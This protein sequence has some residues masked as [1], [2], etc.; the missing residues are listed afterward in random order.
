ME[1]EEDELEENEAVV[2]AQSLLPK[3][4]EIRSFLMDVKRPIILCISETWLNSSV[5]VCEIEVHDYTMYRRDRGERGGGVLVYVPECC[6]SWRRQDLEDDEV[7]AIWSELHLKGELI[8]VCNVYRP[9]DS[10][11]SALD[12]IS[13]MLEIAAGK[14]KELVLMG[15]LNCNMLT[16]N[17]L[18]EKLLLI[19]QENCLTQMISE[20]TRVT[21]NSQTLIDVLFTTTPTSFSALGILPL[22]GSDH[23]MIFGE[24]VERPTSI[25]KASIVRCYKKCNFDELL[26]EL[27]DTPWHIMDIYSSV[28]DMWDCW[29]KLFFS[30]LDRHAPL[31]SVRRR[32]HSLEWIDEEIRQMMR[33]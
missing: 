1:E 31:R 11:S 27:S 23:M 16:Q 14:S 13:N 17:A 26:S 7:E 21:A 4:D 25:Q 6:R 8:L 33:A 22:T 15:D 20:P 5:C 18:S 2:N 12:R 19:T 24:R 10:S 9:P 3:M 32:K 29:K 28:D 30:V